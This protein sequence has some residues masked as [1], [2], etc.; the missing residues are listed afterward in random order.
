MPDKLLD[1]NVLIQGQRIACGVHGEGDPLVLIHGT[2]F[3]SR[4][5]HQVLPQLVTA[6][7][8]VYLYDLLGFGNSERPADSSIDTS[9]SGQ[10]PVLLGLLDYWQL[11]KAHFVAH[12]IGGA[13]AQQLGI[14]HADRLKTLTLIDCV[15]FDSWP[16]K[17]TRQQMQQG[18][19]RLMT[20]PDEE[21]RAHFREWILS[22]TAQP[23]QLIENSMDLYLD[24]ICGPV[25][26]ASLFQ[27]QIKHYDPVH[28]M[29]LTEQ[30]FQLGSIPVQLIW[31]E[32]DNWQVTDWAQKLQAAIPGSR[33]SILPQCGHLAP[34]DQP[35]KLSELVINFIAEADRN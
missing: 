13:V 31:G 12:D 35:Q 33:L 4:I 11:E 18:L 28:T 9:V 14:F 1:D 2:P 26:Q 6:G 17:R 10:L 24:M 16:S 21:H 25:G 29:K 27:H 34:E 22:A 19:E 20:A 30:L 32:N 3:Y 5:W 7:F 8:K 23:E 15:S